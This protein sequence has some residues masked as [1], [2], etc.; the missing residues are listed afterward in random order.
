MGLLRPICIWPFP[1]A[2]VRDLRRVQ[3]FLSVEMSMGQLVT[4]G[5][6][7]AGETPVHFY[8]RCGGV[9]PTPAEVMEKIVTILRGGNDDRLFPS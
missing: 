7:A 8:G 2:A 4:D 3:A 5:Q 6:L 9:I 1:Y